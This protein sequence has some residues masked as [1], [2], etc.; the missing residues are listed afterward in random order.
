MK[1]GI[2]WIV[3]PT[4]RAYIGSSQ[5]VARR[6]RQHRS[7][8]QRGV[9]KNVHLQRAVNKHG[10][11][12]FLFAAIEYCQIDKLTEREQFYIDTQGFESLY[13]LRPIAE[14][15]RGHKFAAHIIEAMRVR[16]R[17]LWQQPEYRAVY[18]AG[19]VGLRATPEAVANRAASLRMRYQCDPALRESVSARMK[20]EWARGVK[21][22]MSTEGRQRVSAAV[23]AR[24]AEFFKAHGDKLRGRKHTEGHR[25]AIS[26]GNMGRVVEPDTR[27]AISAKV[28]A[29]K[30]TSGYK[31]VSLDK[32]LNKWA[33][34]A[35]VGGKKRSYGQHA[36]RE[37]AY[38]WRLAMLA[39]LEYANGGK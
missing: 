14:S 6:L 39:H 23:K 21:R 7:E 37:L 22:E 11:D 30:N 27:R 3:G 20:A 10:I 36:T 29:A 25:A 18:L 28:S 5:D 38:S 16:A 12:V 34:Y 8:L 4:G 2:Y 32:R 1:S 15:N 9:H 26:A 24:G 33:A 35:Q 13:N 19:R 31:G 17:A